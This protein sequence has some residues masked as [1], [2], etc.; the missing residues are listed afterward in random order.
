MQLALP[1]P[2]ST[3]LAKLALC[4]IA[5]LLPPLP[6]AQAAN[7]LSA[8]KTAPVQKAMQETS[9]TRI[10]DAYA[11][12]LRQCTLR[13]SVT[14]E[15]GELLVK[16]GDR[17]HAGQVLARVGASEITAPYEAVVSATM[18]RP[19]EIATAGRHII[20]L[21]D[22]AHMRVVASVPRSRLRELNLD[23]PVQVDVAALSQRVK[24]HKVIVIS[25][26]DKPMQMAKLYLELGDVPGL[27][28]GQPARATFALSSWPSLRP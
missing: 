16:A 7:S 11:E 23:E 27:Q 10:T 24:A 15:I 2:A 5:A 3:S 6:S 13:A 14:G 28:P 12:S 26:G 19:G 8:A 18:A 1:A 25:Q 21:Y 9:E 20:T 4:V 17:V 22:P